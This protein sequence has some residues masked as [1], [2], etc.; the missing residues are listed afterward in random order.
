MYEKHYK[1]ERKEGRREE[2]ER[3]RHGAPDLVLYSCNPS[4]QEAKTG[5]SQLQGLPR[6][7]SEFKASLDN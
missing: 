6:L 7:Q 4:T 5:E 3:R 2:G 1:E